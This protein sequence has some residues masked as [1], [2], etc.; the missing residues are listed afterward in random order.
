M[1]KGPTIPYQNII[2]LR[3]NQGVPGIY[4]VEMQGIDQLSK[5]DYIECWTLDKS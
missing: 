2:R 4:D 3:K 1:K 5:Y